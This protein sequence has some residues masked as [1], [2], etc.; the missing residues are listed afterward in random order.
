MCAM[1]RT[2][3]QRH[4]SIGIVKAPEGQYVRGLTTEQRFWAKVHKN[5]PVPARRPELGPCW[6]WTGNHT[7]RPPKGHGR[8]YAA[9]RS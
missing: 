1:H 6:V 7:S 3:K 5:G 9:G 4:G 2:R 8:F